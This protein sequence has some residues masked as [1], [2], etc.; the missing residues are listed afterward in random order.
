M[1]IRRQTLTEWF[2]DYQLMKL[3]QHHHYVPIVCKVD[4]TA[5]TKRY[6]AQGQRIPL[7]AIVIKAAAMLARNRP[8]V[9]C[10]LIRAP[11]GSRVVQFEDVH[12]NVPV[13]VEI[14]DKKIL[15]ATVVRN[16]DR[17]SLGEIQ[18]ALRAARDR[19][20]EQLP[21]ARRLARNQN[22]L[23][24]RLLLKTMYFAAYHLPGVFFKHAGGISVSSLIRLHEA[25]D[26]GIV[27]HVGFGPTAFSICPGLT[28]TSQEGR[29][30]LHIGIGCDHSALAGLSAVTAADELLRIISKVTEES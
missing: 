5:A 6:E 21:I 17:L 4:I 18:N 12:V 19:T 20:P 1:S 23:A 22:S 30:L 24:T 2:T 13:F 7:T 28:E 3:S 9:N 29:K 25:Q 26:P 14:D 10:A 27:T 15:S 8:E 11:W 16:A